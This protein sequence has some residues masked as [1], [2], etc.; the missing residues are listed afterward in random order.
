MSPVH[1]TMRFNRDYIMGTRKR[2]NWFMQWV[3]WIITTKGN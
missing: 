3:K 2:R 1:D